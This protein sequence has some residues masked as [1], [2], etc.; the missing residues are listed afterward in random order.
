MGVAA[1]FIAPGWG[2]TCPPDR[3][4]HSN[5]FISIIAPTGPVMAMHLA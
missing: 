5:F 4:T 1:R 3:I 2:I